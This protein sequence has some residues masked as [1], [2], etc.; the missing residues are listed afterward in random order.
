LA[1]ERVEEVMALGLLDSANDFVGNPAANSRAIWRWAF[2][3]DEELS[4]DV[5]I[6]KPSESAV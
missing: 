1:E 4:E 3:R 2:K 6:E 5:G